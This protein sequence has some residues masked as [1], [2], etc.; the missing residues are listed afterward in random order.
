LDYLSNPDSDHSSN[1]FLSGE[2]SIS[3]G[4]RNRHWLRT[5]V[6]RAQLL[7]AGV[8]DDVA[9]IVLL[10]ELRDM[11][12]EL[13]DD[14]ELPGQ[15]VMHGLALRLLGQI[16]VRGGIARRPD[17]AAAFV[18]LA[19]H[20]R[21]G[22]YHELQR[23]I[24]RCTD[25]LEPAATLSNPPAHRMTVA[26]VI[27]AIDTRYTQYNLTLAR[28]A[29]EAGLS[30]CHLS[31]ILNQQTGRGFVDQLHDRRVAAAQQL[32]DKSSLSIKEIASAVGYRSM[33][34][35]G[36]HY[37]RRFDV[38]PAAARAMAAR[39]GDDEKQIHRVRRAQKLTTDNKIC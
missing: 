8:G 12:R 9:P 25:A 20:G 13:P 22:W 1:V 39:V 29:R 18:D 16:A 14:M 31:R 5:W 30:A 27:N 21:D 37:K 4:G 32:L 38:T 34:Q 2:R 35:L 3:I 7:V 23:L 26:K 11:V 24:K 28:L 6:G 17:I 10:S 15:L 36:R 33:T 19:S